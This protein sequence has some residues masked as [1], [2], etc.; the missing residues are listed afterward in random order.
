MRLISEL[1][2]DIG[3]YKGVDYT[4]LYEISSKGRFRSLDRVVS[5]VIHGKTIKRLF[6][7]SIREAHECLN[8]YMDVILTKNHKPHRAKL[9]RLV[10]EYF[11]PNPNG[12]SD[13]NHID[14]NKSNN[15]VNNLEWCSHKEN[16]NHGTRNERAGLKHRKPV[17]QLDLDGNLVKIWDCQTDTENGGFSF[18][19]VNKCVRNAEKTHMGFKWVYLE[20]YEKLNSTF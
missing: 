1:W 20:D 8:G 2:K 4:G 11:I 5:G 3:V 14:E 19:C 16:C 13:V 7:G 9:H 10:A 12:Y 15:D 18:S 17:V 6:K